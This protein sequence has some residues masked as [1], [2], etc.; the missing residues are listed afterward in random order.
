M[1]VVVEFVFPAS[2]GSVPYA[3]TLTS[4]SE[5][6]MDRISTI[7]CELGLFDSDGHYVFFCFLLFLG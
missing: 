3:M 5:E 2:D 1:A 7:I 4:V 6:F